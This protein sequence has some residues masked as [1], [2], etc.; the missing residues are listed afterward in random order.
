[1]MSYFYTVRDIVPILKKGP[2]TI[3]EITWELGC[4]K[5]RYISEETI[6]LLVKVGTDIEMFC[7][8]DDGSILFLGNPYKK[9]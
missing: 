8:L 6:K 9:E 1:M 5:K 7:E 3:P 2:A 4:Q